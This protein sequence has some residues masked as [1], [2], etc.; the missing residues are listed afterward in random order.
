M[1]KEEALE[2]LDTIPTIGEQ[3]EALEIAIKSLERE[4]KGE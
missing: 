2:I 4:I 3:V 1:T